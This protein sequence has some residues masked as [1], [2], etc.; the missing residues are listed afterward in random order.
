MSVEEEKQLIDAGH[1]PGD[2][3]WESLGIANYVTW[4]RIVGCINKR[5]GYRW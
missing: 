3:E 1:L 4:P 5:E 2:E